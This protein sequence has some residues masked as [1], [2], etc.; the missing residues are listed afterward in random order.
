MRC[1]YAFVRPLVVGLVLILAAGALPQVAL[2]GSTAGA[3]SLQIPPGARAEATGRFYQSVADDAFAPWWNPAG[4]AFTRGVNAGLMHSRLAEGLSEDAVYFEYLGASTYI[5]GW[6]GLAGTI[7]YLNYGESPLTD[8]S[9]TQLGTFSSF[10]FAPSV[11]LGTTV[12]P[13]LGLGM[14]LKFVYINLLSGVDSS[15]RDQLGLQGGQGTSFGVDLGALYRLER[16]TDSFFGSGP[17]T[18]TL[19]IG[20]T[21]ANLGPNISLTED[22]QSDPLPR[23][24]K[25]GVSY[26]VRVPNSYSVLAGLGVEKSLVFADFPDSVKSQ[27]S[28]FER[29]EIIASGGVEVG[30]NDLV[31]GR[32]GYLRDESG[33]ITAMTYGAGFRLKGFGFDF[34]SIPQA[35]DLPRV[36]KFSVVA[37]FD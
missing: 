20:A 13:N 6:G 33:G 30:F 15:V 3:F 37:R 1:R 12:L 18:T 9:S 10:E 35:L 25:L 24:L 26:G 32:M 7:S 27:L 28:Y 11:A 21:V 23:N 8:G 17:A 31:F 14:N 19:G 34:A 2:A 29:H 22:K 5:E 16:E 4:L 36:S